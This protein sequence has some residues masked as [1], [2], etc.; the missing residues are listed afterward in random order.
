MLPPL[1]YTKSMSLRTQH[2]VIV[3]FMSC[4][5]FYLK[6][7]F[8]QKKFIYLATYKILLKYQ[9]IK[10]NTIDWGFVTIFFKYLPMKSSEMLKILFCR[11]VRHMNNNFS[12]KTFY[13]GTWVAF[14]PYQSLLLIID[15]VKPVKMV[16]Q[17]FL[18]KIFLETLS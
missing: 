14:Q 8:S 11:L 12:P 15:L 7:I 5:S 4:P 9:K 3:C 13:T 18:I 17:D 1:T 6:K 10:T 2:Y 16:I